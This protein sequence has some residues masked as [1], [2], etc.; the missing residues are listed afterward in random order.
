VCGTGIKRI[1]LEMSVNL[2]YSSPCFFI[3][4]C[5]EFLLEEV[6][7]LLKSALRTCFLLNVIILS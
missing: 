1:Y 5:L 7:D 4:Y 6:M 3:R 2:D